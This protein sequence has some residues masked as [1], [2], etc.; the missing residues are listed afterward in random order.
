M[1]PVTSVKRPD[2][3][4]KTIQRLLSYM[5][6]HK[7]LML[8]VA[9][10]VTLSAAANLLG[11]YMLRPI[12]DTYTKDPE[13]SKLWLVISIEIGIY[14]IGVLSTLGYSQIMVRLAQKIIYEMRRDIFK[15]MEKLPL[16]YFDCRTHGEIMSNYTNDIDTLSEA[17]NN[18]FAM[19][20]S[21]SIQI[22]G[23]IILLFVLNWLLSIIVIVCYI[24]MTTYI[25]YASKK[26]KK[27]FGDQQRVMAR[28]NGFVEE[29]ISG[30]KVVKVFNHEQANVESF[31]KE[32]EALR[33]AGYTALKY[34]M[35]MIP[36]VVS[37]SY[38]NYAVVAILGGLIALGYIPIVSFTL[39]GIASYLVFVRQAAMP[40]NQFTNQSN[41]LLN[42]LAGA[43]R[44]FKLMDEE[45]EIDEGNITLIQASH[46]EW[47]WKKPSG[48]EIPLKGDVRFYNVDFSYFPGKRILSNLSLYAKPGQKIAFVGSTGAG[49]T[50][51]TNLI[52]RFYEIE[53]G[54]ITY[55]GVNISEIKKEDLRHSLGIVLQDTSLFSGTIRENIRYGRLSAS[56]QE[57][58]EAA[59][60]VNAHQFIKK[61]PQ[62]YD[63]FVSPD[64]G[65]LSQGQR[66]LLSIARAAVADTPVLILDEATSSI[67]TR[68]ERLVQEGMD[69]L[70]KNR[71]VFVIAHRLSTVRNANAIL[72]LDH[73]QIMER[74]THEELLSQKGIYYKLY[75]GKLELE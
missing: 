51:I 16:S 38:I 9:I 29:T 33:D 66:Q 55:D 27:A 32:N 50:T 10:L 45:P 49:K 7:F 34:S 75:T 70:M 36:M 12:I 57:I 65:S 59:K 68:T 31:R 39:G 67:D 8:L 37:I 47:A 41:L 58:E 2:D 35:S 15:Q 44:L 23:L 40:I 62:G 42:G 20:I 48:E 30:Q 69:K 71:T 25:I 53:G 11:T 3:L 28:V 22:V 6:K 72:V 19:L 63:T 52:N 13:Y 54:T 18:A 43:E 60:L 56:D 17:L 1:P 64:G 61:L 26:S 21:N 46:Q 73:G 4:K 14:G 74:G 24:L 5:G